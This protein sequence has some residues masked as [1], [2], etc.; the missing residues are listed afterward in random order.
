MV[1]HDTRLAG[2]AP[3]IA[4][5][6]YTVDATTPIQHAIGWITTYARNNGGLTDLFVMAHGYEAIISDAAAQQSVMRGGFGVQICRESLL[7]GNL[8]LMSSLD[9]LIGIITLY[10]CAPADTHPQNRSRYGDGE[11]FCRELAA[12]TNAEVVAAVETQY[13]NTS[14]T[15]NQINFGNWEGAVYRFSPDGSKSR[16]Q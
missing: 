12:I 4:P 15:N 2:T 11:R 6:T 14:G 5:N 16:I 8:Q 3:A 10:C 1:W 7:P 9:G 13:Y